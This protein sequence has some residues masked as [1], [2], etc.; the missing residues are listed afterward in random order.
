MKKNLQVAT[1][2]RNGSR[3]VIDMERF[4]VTAVIPNDSAKGF[5]FVSMVLDGPI[6]DEPAII[7]GYSYWHTFIASHYGKM[8]QEVAIISWSRFY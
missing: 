7:N 5:E 4:Y 2:L 1:Y 6:P 8:T 3:G